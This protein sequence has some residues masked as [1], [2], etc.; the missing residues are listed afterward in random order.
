MHVD[1]ISTHVDFV[2]LQSSWNGVY[3]ADPEAQF[4][5]SW[6]WLDKVFSTY[7]DDWFIL[8][9]RPSNHRNNYIAFLP[10]RMHTRFSSRSKSLINEIRVAG[11]YTW[12]D[13]AGLICHPEFQE[14]AIPL[15]ASK[16]KQMH[17]RYLLL[18]NL[19]ISDQRLKLFMNEFNTQ[20]FKH[21]FLKQTGRTD[22]VN[23]LLCPSID[24]PGSYENYLKENISANTRQKLRRF[25]RKV[26]N[27]STLK[28]IHSTKDTFQSDLNI[29]IDLWKSKWSK[30][31]GKETE[32]LA[33]KYRQILEIGIKN[34]SL[35]LPVLWDGD[36]PLG[37]LGILIDRQKQALL[38]FV[39]GRDEEYNN[40]PPGLV[41]HAHSIKWAI[42]NGFKTYEFLRGDER[43]KYSLGGINKHICYL[44]ISTRSGTN[45]NAN[46]DP[47]YINQAIEKARE[48][49]NRRQYTK[50]II[51]FQQILNQQPDN[52][53][54]HYY[55]GQIFYN[56]RQMGKAAVSFDTVINLSADDSGT[57]TNTHQKAR[58][59]LEKLQ[60][61]ENLNKS[62]L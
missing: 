51:S 45:L 35:F 37:A 10:L 54:A 22:K 21:R 39:A 5:L 59:Y 27:S 52:L 61:T 23:R 16:L 4:F 57:V 2:K 3:E 43:F 25:I 62:E 9:V 8:A 32:R 40:P 20:T 13:Y 12:S 42:E 41:L 56:Q 50:A 28:I 26:D 30:H 19:L 47:A 1:I 33:K 11:R 36:K 34:N 55:L 60:V 38:Y 49:K 24:L 58:Y 48:Y 29:L 18:K 44:V 6:S 46:L 15:L 17:W 31:K 7:K 53:R 14:Y